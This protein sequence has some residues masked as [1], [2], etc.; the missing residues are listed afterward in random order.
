MSN[1]LA[2]YSMANDN[3]IMLLFVI[4][5]ISIS[6]VFL[7]NGNSIMERVKCIFYYES[8]SSPFSDRTHITRICNTLMYVQTLYY[9]SIIASEYILRNTPQFTF[10]TV[11]PLMGILTILFASVLL[12]KRLSY[13]AVNTILF[14]RHAVSEW[15][16]FYFFTIKLLG[17]A[18]TPAIIVILFLP[19]ISFT[20]V[21]IYLLIVLIAYV[22]TILIGLFKII[23][24]QRRNFLDIFLYLCALEFLPLGIVWKSVLQLSEFLTIKN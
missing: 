7:M 20:I 4:N 15:R 16:S 13:D 9:S 14:D 1:T 5:M 18:L 12:F 2:P 17:F 10:D 21:K 22:Y 6:Y 11:L 23:F 24:A 8:K 19:G 3:A